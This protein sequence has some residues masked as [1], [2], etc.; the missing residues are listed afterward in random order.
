MQVGSITLHNP[1]WGNSEARQ[2][3]L[4]IVQHARDKVT[5]RTHVKTSSRHKVKM[6]VR[7][8]SYS[9]I[10]DLF[11]SIKSQMHQAISIT[12][13]ENQSWTNCYILTNP[14]EITSVAKKCSTDYNTELYEFSFEFEGTKA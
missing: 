13:W 1:E 2:N 4:A 7:Y 11:N 5:Q 12:D 10:E 3:K 6:T 8:A 14:L 9:S